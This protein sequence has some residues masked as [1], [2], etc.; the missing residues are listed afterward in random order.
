LLN[1]QKYSRRGL[2]RR[3]ARRASIILHLWE[4]EG[5]QKSPKGSEC[6]WKL[7]KIAP[8]SASEDSAKECR[9]G[10]IL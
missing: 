5:R 2:S 10:R 7:R 1:T 8:T 4:K 6:S 3:I 9:S